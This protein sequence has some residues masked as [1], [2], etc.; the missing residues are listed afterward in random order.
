M[1]A[2]LTATLL[3]IIGFV[4]AYCFIRWLFWNEDYGRP[5][6]K[7]GL[8]IYL[9]LVGVIW[10]LGIALSPTIMVVAFNSPHMNERHI[11]VIGLNLLA[12][13]LSIWAYFEARSK[14]RR[15]WLWCVGK[16]NLFRVFIDL[17][18]PFEQAMK[19]Y[20]A[21]PVARVDTNDP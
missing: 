10:G 21:L 19:I 4:A 18:L 12:I 9:I 7:R 15:P 13:A 1:T 20:G 17:E 16:E 11:G 8:L 3:E 2:F 14:G 6:V 5:M